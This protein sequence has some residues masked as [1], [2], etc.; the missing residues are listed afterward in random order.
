MV[1]NLLKNMLNCYKWM[2][3][4]ISHGS[5]SDFVETVTQGFVAGR[6]RVHD[7]GFLIS[8]SLLLKAVRRSFQLY[9]FYHVLQPHVSN[10]T[11]SNSLK[12]GKNNSAVWKRRMYIVYSARFVFPSTQPPVA[13]RGLAEERALL[14]MAEMK[15]SIFPDVFFWIF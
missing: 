10:W 14:M 1:N 4:N 12:A 15:C 5:E 6:K 13:Q 11:K 2:A 8:F 9:I 7:R 3:C